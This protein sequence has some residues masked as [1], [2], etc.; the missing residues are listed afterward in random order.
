VLLVTIA[1]VVI[2]VDQITK[3]LVVNRLANGSTVSLLGGTVTLEYARN[4][5]AAFSLFRADGSV[6]AV[7]A[8]AVSCGIL[9]YYGRTSG[10]P[11]LVRIALG[12]ILGGAIGN[13]VDRIRH[14]FVVDFVDL[15]W[16]PVFNV[17]DSCIVVG[18]LLLIL[19]SLLGPPD[20]ASGG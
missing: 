11:L 8:I 1:I 14:G 7:I 3:Q 12:M 10:A 13:L 15:H 9:V 5:G 19:H 17:A 18:V 4:T 16:W 2:A 20:E 6:L